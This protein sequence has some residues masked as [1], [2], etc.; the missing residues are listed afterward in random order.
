MT[1]TEVRRLLT[2]LDLR[3]SKSLGQNFLI[4]NN[5]LE[6]ITREADIRTNETVVEVG[7]GLGALTL[8]LADRAAK[9]IAIEKDSRLAAHIRAH[10]PEV[11]LIEGDESFPA[12]AVNRTGQETELGADWNKPVVEAAQR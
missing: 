4:D 8:K 1:L 2:E 9:V 3:P 10:F 11:D 6:I 7:P 12:P 5:I